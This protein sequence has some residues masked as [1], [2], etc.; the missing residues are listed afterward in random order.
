MKTVFIKTVRST[1]RSVYARGPLARMYE[2]GKRYTF[3]EHLPAHVGSDLGKLGNLASTYRYRP[4]PIGG[5][6]CLLCLGET[7]TKGVPVMGAWCRMWDDGE[8]REACRYPEMRRT[9]CDF[10]VIGEI[11]MPS[12][13]RDSCVIDQ[14]DDDDIDHEWAATLMPSC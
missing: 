13:L 3:P 11:F 2:I 7:K 14:P 4:E 12:H 6:R 5:N 1:G 9:S 8:Y 10:E